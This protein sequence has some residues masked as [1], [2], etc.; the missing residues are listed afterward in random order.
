VAPYLHGIT[1]EMPETRVAWREEVEVIKDALRE[2][3]PP[4]DL[5]ELYPIQSFEIL[6]DRSARVFKALK[7]LTSEIDFPVWIV[8][9]EGRVEV[10]TL[11]DVVAR[12]EAV[13][14]GR[15][16]L[17]PPS[18]GVLSSN[19]MLDPKEKVRSDTKYDVADEWFAID[20]DNQS[21]VR[22]R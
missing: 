20:S 11:S 5:L 7:S 8:S 6:S 3:Y 18:I 10:A 17:L 4:E 1:D 13:I 9:D 21:T 2:D 15:L 19:G 22:M 12:G 16:L 14:Q